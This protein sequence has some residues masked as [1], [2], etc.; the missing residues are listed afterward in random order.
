VITGRLAEI[1]TWQCT[2][3]G[4]FWREVYHWQGLDKKSQIIAFLNQRY[5]LKVLIPVVHA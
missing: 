3:E 4:K 2:P 5:N 1:A